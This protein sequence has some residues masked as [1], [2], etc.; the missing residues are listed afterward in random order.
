MRPGRGTRNRPQDRC[1][2]LRMDIASSRGQHAPPARRHLYA[3]RV[4]SDADPFGRR[5]CAEYSLPRGDV[6]RLAQR[7]GA[8]QIAGPPPKRAIGGCVGGAEMLV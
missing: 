2:H 5:R 8:A 7:H 4:Q 6:G 1:C 3:I